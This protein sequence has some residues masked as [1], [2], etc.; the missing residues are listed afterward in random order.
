MVPPLVSQ[1]TIFPHFPQQFMLYK[2]GAE[3]ITADYLIPCEVFITEYTIQNNRNG[4]YFFKCMSTHYLR[5][6]TRQLNIFLSNISLKLICKFVIQI[7]AR[8]N[9]EKNTMIYLC[10]II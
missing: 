5:L 4:K 9:I 2:C 8:Q 7:L 3:Y 1:H 6:F 10:F